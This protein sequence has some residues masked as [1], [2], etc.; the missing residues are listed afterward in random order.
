MSLVAIPLSLV[1]IPTKLLPTAIRLM[2]SATRLVTFV[3]LLVLT[4]SLAPGATEGRQMPSSSVS[5]EKGDYVWH[6]E[7]SPVGAVVIIV[8]LP[9]QALAVYRNGIPIGRS[10][11]SSGKSGHDTPTGIFTILQKN[12]RHHSNIYHEATMP[13]MERLTWSGIAMHG[14]ELPGYA[15][16]HGCV[17]LPLEFARKL[18]TL[19]ADGTTVI[20][21]DHRFHFGTQKVPALLFTSST[22]AIVPPGVTYWNLSKSPEGP[23]SIVASSAD[24]EVYV[25]R[26]GLEIGRSP[27]GGLHGLSGL[28][29]YYALGTHDQEG[30]QN[31]LSTASIVGRPPLVK[32]LINQ[33]SVDPRFLAAMRCLITTGT[34]LIIT[35][36]PVYSGTPRNSK[37]EIL[38][39]ATSGS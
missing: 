22:E 1:A 39:T 19:T 10:T 13:Y 6:P 15:D 17:R 9:D 33:V 27:F 4:M 35:D 16:S 37:V 28:Y 38:T 8:S 21:T 23:L 7:T 32:D 18:Y 2:P 12:V 34:T 36:A 29:V 14:G 20:V 30:R 3:I 11:I 31:W 5:L 25:Y 24:G 26:H